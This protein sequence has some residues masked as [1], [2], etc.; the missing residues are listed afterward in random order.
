MKVLEDDTRIVDGKTV[1]T[2]FDYLEH[3]KEGFQ[4]GYIDLDRKLRGL[5]PGDTY[6]IGARPAMGKT[7]FAVNLMRNIAINGNRKVAYFS[8]AQSMEHIINRLIKLESEESCYITLWHRMPGTNEMCNVIGNCNVIV[9]DTW[10]ISIEDFDRVLS[11]EKMAGVNVVFIDYLQLLTTENK[12]PDRA[13]EIRY[14]AEELKAIAVKHNVSI[15]VLSQ[16]SSR[17]EEREDHKPKLEDF[18]EEN[19]AYFFDNVLFVYRDDYYDSDDEYKD[20][21]TIIVEKNKFCNPCEVYLEW[22]P[23]CAKFC[24]LGTSRGNKY[25]V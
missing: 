1:L 19:L 11:S 21:A 23:E 12:N 17:V 5:I 24:D 3:K 13:V 22:V 25:Y 20:K 15:M 16:I 8:P 6:L 9:N 10:G 18:E 4:T 14:I 7:A 2:Q